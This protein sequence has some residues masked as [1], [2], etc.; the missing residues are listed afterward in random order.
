[1]AIASA[2]SYI[3]NNKKSSNSNNNNN[4]NN[5]LQIFAHDVICTVNEKL[6][7]YK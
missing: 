6:D 1:M 5:F 7:I 3:S 2:K 4:N